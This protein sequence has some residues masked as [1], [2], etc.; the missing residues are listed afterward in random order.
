MRSY[1]FP[2][3][4]VTEYVIPVLNVQP[5]RRTTLHGTAFFVNSN[6]VFMTAGHVIR[7]AQEEAANTNG[8]VA[9]G[10]PI[11][12]TNPAAITEVGD[13]SFANAPYDIAVGIS[14][15]AS[16][17]LFRLLRPFDASILKNVVTFG[18]P[19]SAV[20]DHPSKAITLGLRAHKGYIVRPLAPGRLLGHD[21]PAA[22]ELNFPVPS[23][24]SGAPL[25]LEPPA[26]RPEAAMQ[27][28]GG[29]AVAGGMA[30]NVRTVPSPALSLLGVCVGTQEAETVVH[31]YTEVVDGN[32]EFREKTSKVELYGLAHDITWLGSWRPQCLGGAS[33]GDVIKPSD[34]SSASGEAADVSEPASG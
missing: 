8:I 11:S 16:K 9:I 31:A 34:Y 12:P 5:S 6:G 29:L 21:H 24:M 10:Q 33:L 13:V 25:L 32:I 1:E 28:S 23:A 22:F 14:N 4:S 27:A 3:W 18:Y 2:K 7:A 26:T 19:A 20:G 17:A 30:V 15:T